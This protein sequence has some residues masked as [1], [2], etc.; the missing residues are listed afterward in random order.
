M[1]IKTIASGSKGNCTIVL[2]KDT[3]LIID[4][5]ISFLTL[6]KTLEENSLS[7]DDFSGILVTHCHKDHT[8]GLATLINKTKLNA[9]IPE[10][11]YESLKEFI[12]YQRCTFIDDQFEINDVEIELIHTS[13]DAPSSVGYIMKQEDK[14]LV[15]VTDTGYINRKY[16]E[17]MKD[18]NCYLIESNHDEVMLMDGPY[19]RFLKERVISDSGHLANA[20][21]AKYLKKI[22]GD[23][24][25]TIILAHLSETNNTKEK[26]LEAIAEQELPKKINIV[27]AEQ[28]KEGPMIEV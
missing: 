11:M 28:Y 9:Y 17:K 26:A 4:M 22:I 14:S 8:K 7:F 25:K 2:C 15:Y 10:G 3:N 6:K 23:H 12:P 20:T 24:T 27:V 19:P 18:K 1:K 5:G 21:T 13:H 16:L